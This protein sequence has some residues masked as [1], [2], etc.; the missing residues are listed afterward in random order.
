MTGPAPTQGTVRRGLV[1]DVETRID[2]RAL[3]ASGRN[4]HPR[5]MPT[6]LQ[7]IVAAAT[8]S[9]DVDADGICRSLDLR[10][11]DCVRAGEGALCRL[12][13]RELAR[14]HGGGGVLVTFN[15]GHD[16]SMVRLAT[17]RH[18]HF[19][20]AGAASWIHDVQERHEDLMLD[21]SGAVGA[22][23]TS[24][25]DL[26]AAL[27]IHAPGEVSLGKPVIGVEHA[28]CETDV[29]ATMALYLHVLSERHRSE[30]PLREGIPA[31]ADLIDKRLE[32]SPNLRTALCGRLFQAYAAG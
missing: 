17:L 25:A 5:G 21:L 24:L 1:L 8:L 30:R 7:V 12:L 9:F 26:S 32:R 15:D 2:R 28:K 29:I 3:Q 23:W 27:G 16:L 19:Q 4:S 10:S 13:D 31:L 11:A 6:A 20:S 22:R 18:R 14:V